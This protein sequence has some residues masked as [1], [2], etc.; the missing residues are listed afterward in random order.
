VLVL[1][2]IVPM[3]CRLPS[4]PRTYPY[5]ADVWN[6]LPLL[7]KLGKPSID[8]SKATTLKDVAFLVR[9]RNVE[10]VTMALRTITS[11]HR[12]LQQISIYLPVPMTTSIGYNVRE[13][14]GK[15]TY[16]QWSDLDCL[17][18][19]LWESRS[20]RPRITSEYPVT[21]WEVVGDFVGR[22]LPEMTRIGTVDLLRSP[23]EP[24]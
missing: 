23:N 16:R 3:G 14:I 6:F 22:L 17:L 18:V 19:Q 1:R 8:L 7:V 5:F 12:D 24:A 9:S 15:T 4:S 13:T 20:I 11:K 2:P 21:Q 10:W